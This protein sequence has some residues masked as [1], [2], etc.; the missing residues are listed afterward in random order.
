MQRLD[1]GVVRFLDTTA[2]R[3]DSGVL[4]RL[5]LPPEWMARRPDVQAW[6]AGYN[7]KAWSAGDYLVPGAESVEFDEQCPDDVADALTE[8]FEI[9]GLEG[10]SIVLWL[11]VGGV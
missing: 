7:V 5:D 2:V 9:E 6:L 8:L 3:R 4:F 1:Y 10:E 11:Y